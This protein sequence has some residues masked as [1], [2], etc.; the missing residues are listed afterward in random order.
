M[1]GPETTGP[2]AVRARLDET[3]PFGRPL[4]RVLQI[5]IEDGG[6]TLPAL[7]AA[8]GVPRREVERLLNAL[9]D[10]ARPVDGVIRLAGE[11]YRA[12]LEPPVRPATPEHEELAGHA[13][14][15]AAMREL[16]EAAP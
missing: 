2:A 16:T 13:A 9:G 5:L 8:T 11:E 6:T 3:G 10:D 15:L 4:R 12:L 1:A 7:V 14:E